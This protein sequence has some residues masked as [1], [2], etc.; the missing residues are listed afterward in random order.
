MVDTSAR[1]TVLG[2][3]SASTENGTCYV[4]NDS[5][6]QCHLHNTRNVNVNTHGGHFG[7][8]GAS[9]GN[10]TSYVG[11]ESPS[12]IFLPNNKLYKSVSHRVNISTLITVLSLTGAS[13]DNGTGYV[14]NVINNHS[15]WHKTR[16][17]NRY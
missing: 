10:G 6:S 16:N 3:N 12:A 7:L 2:L 9:T 15:H 11:I 13:T 17:I 5:P 8:I 14:G 1:V 4:G